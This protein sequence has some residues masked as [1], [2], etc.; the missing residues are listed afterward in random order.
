ML[1]IGFIYTIGV[2]AHAGEM[3]AVFEYPV[4]MSEPGAQGLGP[5]TIVPAGTPLKFESEK[6]YWVQAKGRVPFL[7]IP[8]VKHNVGEPLKLQMPEVAKWPSYVVQRE[9]DSKLAEL[10]EE[11][12][13]FQDAMRAKN[14]ADAEKALNRMESIARLDYLHFLR[15]ALR[16]IQGDVESAK[17]S[18]RQGLQR[19]P[20]NVQGQKF[21]QTL[22]GKSQ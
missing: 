1:S 18:V 21:L 16:F 8:Q 12:T 9:M 17:E 4:E 7:V 3:Q 2:V 15:G 20:A 6:V 19:Y 13:A 10:V 5:V 14:A 11:L 22:E